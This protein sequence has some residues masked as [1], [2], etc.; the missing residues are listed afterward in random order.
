MS[1][2]LRLSMIGIT[3]I[4]LIAGIVYI[5]Q[6]PSAFISIVQ[7]MA[8]MDGIAITVELAKPWWTPH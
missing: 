7:V 8:F 3:W 5:Q 1:N 4:L 2:R 6:I